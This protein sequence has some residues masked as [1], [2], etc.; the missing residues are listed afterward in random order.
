MRVAT[1][2]VAPEDAVVA[3]GVAGAGAEAEL[4]LVTHV[5]D[6]DR[7]TATV[8]LG[9][10]DQLDGDALR[11]AV[12]TIAAA[13]ARTHGP[14]AWTLDPSLPLTLDEQARAVVE[15]ASF[16]AYDTGAWRSSRSR[17]ELA[18]LTLLGAPEADAAA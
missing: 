11:T 7:L 18:S 5:R 10:P 1:S 8:G 9:P 3:S 6:G 13:V 12:S 4:G 16:G 14:L 15:G 2:S 17:R